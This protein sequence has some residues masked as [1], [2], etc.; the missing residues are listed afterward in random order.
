MKVIIEFRVENAPF[1]ADWGGQIQKILERASAQ[2]R[3]HGFPTG[4]EKFKIVGRLH[5]SDGNPV[6]HIRVED[7]GPE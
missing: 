2:L 7:G 5:D 6:G 1:V 3:K 4:P